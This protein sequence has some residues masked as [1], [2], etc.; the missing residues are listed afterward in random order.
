M[1]EEADLSLH[2]SL[3]LFNNA[4]ESVCRHMPFIHQRHILGGGTLDANGPKADLIEW[5]DNCGPADGSLAKTSN[6][7][8][9][10][11]TSGY[12]LSLRVVAR[13]WM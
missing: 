12:S 1:M 2:A 3:E 13:K 10:V 5:D 9:S 8:P 4:Q 11:D 6:C 7:Q